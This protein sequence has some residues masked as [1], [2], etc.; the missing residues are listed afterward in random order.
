MEKYVCA[1]C[2]YVYDPEKGDPANGIP[3]ETPF[4]NLTEEWECPVC[5][6]AVSDFE[7]E[8]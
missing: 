3:A 2:G 4:E 1:V 5:G 6:A 8:S 7:P